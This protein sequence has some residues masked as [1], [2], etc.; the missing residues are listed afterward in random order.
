MCEEYETPS[1]Y[2]DKALEMFLEEYT[3]EV[4]PEQGE[5]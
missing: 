4:K 1:E 3:V 5:Q 2:F